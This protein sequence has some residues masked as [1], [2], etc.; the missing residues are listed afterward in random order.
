MSPNFEVICNICL[1]KCN[2][3]D[4]YI[5]KAEQI[6]KDFKIL[7]QKKTIIKQEPKDFDYDESLAFMNKSGLNNEYT[8]F[9]N[10]KVENYQFQEFND[11]NGFQL[12]HESESEDNSYQMP[13]TSKKKPASAKKPKTSRKREKITELLHCP[14]PGCER[15]FDNRGKLL[16]HMQYHSKER[17][18]QVAIPFNYFERN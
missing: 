10:I 7:L 3:Y 18:H 15:R 16:F 9:P 8:D 5:A 6:Q 17:P 13:S 2:E 14:E 4:E 12:D 11:T 1:E